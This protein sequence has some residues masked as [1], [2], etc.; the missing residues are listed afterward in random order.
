[1]LLFRVSIPP[2]RRPLSLPE[3]HTM[4]VNLDPIIDFLFEW[5]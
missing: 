1:M 4:R 3:Q 5:E 2:S